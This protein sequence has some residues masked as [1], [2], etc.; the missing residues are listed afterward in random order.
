MPCDTFRYDKDEVFIF[1]WFLYTDVK[2][3]AALGLLNFQYWQSK[4]HIG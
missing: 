3:I 1:V 2:V 4:W